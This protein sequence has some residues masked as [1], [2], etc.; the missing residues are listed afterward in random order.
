MNLSFSAEDLAFRDQ[1]KLFIDKY[2]PQSVRKHPTQADIDAW[3]KAVYEQGWTAV[4]W[5]VE[6][7]GTGWTPTQKYFW[8]REAAEAGCPSLSPFG[9]TMLAPVLMAYGTQ[10]QQK[11]HL[12]KILSREISWC[13][14]YSEPGSGSDL[15]SLSTKA[16]QKEGYYIV[17]G[18]KAWTSNA[19]LAD[20]IFCLV[21]TDSSGRKQQGIS[22]LL[23]DMQTPGITIEPVITLGDQHV[24]NA[25]TFVDVKVPL[26]NLVGEENKGWTYA[27][28]LLTHERT[29]LA[30]VASSRAALNRLKRISSGQM[31]AG[32]SLIEDPDFLRKLTEVEIE[33]MALEMSELRTLATVSAGKAPG[34]ESS[35]LKIKGTEVRQRLTELAIEA[36]G[37]YAIPFPELIDGKNEPPIGPDYSRDTSFNYLASRVA[38]IYGGS[39]EVQRNIIAKAVLGL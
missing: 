35:I 37:Y 21:R 36:T 26:T 13:Q 2:Y 4:N 17:N 29:G 18:A 39:S 33:L 8:D 10:T 7:G 27:K 24:V 16:I 23:I 31:S 14:G 15:A 9:L 22:F 5:P 20:W 34:P 1:V 11:E 38:T 12:P 19:H 6:F 28:G 3:H 30:G 32:S 25:V